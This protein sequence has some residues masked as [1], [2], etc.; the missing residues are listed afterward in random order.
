MKKYKWNKKKFLKNMFELSIY[1]FEFAFY[2]YFIM[3][4]L[5]K[6]LN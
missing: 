6:I 2:V 3:K 1:I 4:A 5:E